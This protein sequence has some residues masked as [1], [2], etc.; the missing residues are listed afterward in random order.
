MKNYI[1]IERLKQELPFINFVLTTKNVDA[2][3]IEDLK[4]TFS[5]N[6]FTLKNL[7]S[8]IQIHSD[9]V[10][11][12]DYSNIGNKDEGDALITNLENVPLLIFTADC[13]PVT[14]IDKSKKAIGL[15]HAGWKGTYSEIAK[16][17]IEKMKEL[18]NS[19]PEDLICVIGASIGEC[20]YEVSEDLYNKFS[21]KFK[22]NV[23]RLYS[24]DNDKYYLNLQNI[25]KHSLKEIGVK[26]EN[27]INLD[28]CT[29]C[30]C[31]KFHSYRAHDKT[32]YRIGTILEIKK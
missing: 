1:E 11:T 14:I 18:Y 22:S 25:N 13:V 10:N 24:I 32:P 7:T 9:I 16:K 20:C 23:D 5:N 19:N 4:S 12:V 6:E 29:N 2:K 28:I 8:N 30:N 3:N 15:A 27:I 31:D 21:N 17:T 26:E